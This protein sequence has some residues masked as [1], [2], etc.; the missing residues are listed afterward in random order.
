VIT[1]KAEGRREIEEPAPGGQAVLVLGMH[2][3]GT[4]AVTELVHRLG[5]PAGQE[6]ERMPAAR[7]NPRGHWEISRLTEVDDAVLAE[8]GSSWSAPPERA[9]DL[10]STSPALAERAVETW[11]SVFGDGDAVWKDPRACLTLPFW[12]SLLPAP[13]A[14]V[15]VLRDPRAVAASLHE[16]DGFSTAY[17]LA[18]WERHLRLALG[19]VAGLPTE[20]V[21]YEDLITDPR[22][23]AGAL[24]RF[25]APFVALRPPGEWE[26]AGGSVDARLNRSVVQPLPLSAAQ[27]DL[28]ELA[29]GLVGAEGRFLSIELP[30]ETPGLALAFAE[31]QRGDVRAQDLELQLAGEREAADRHVE[32]LRAD[33]VAR[34]AQASE[35]AEQLIDARA[36]VEDLQRAL[37]HVRSRRAFRLLQA[38]RRPFRRR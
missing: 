34:S 4:S 3:S 17:G 23:V 12:R 31:H 29:A 2:R 27:H 33:L 25:L 35:L 18:L 30:P 14:V 8:V 28:V 37:D 38:V 7:S 9:V 20:V 24:G 11:R 5:L 15:L 36:Q 6:Q 21:R 10:A 1:S 19:A 22:A 32:L 16:R 13:P 26:D